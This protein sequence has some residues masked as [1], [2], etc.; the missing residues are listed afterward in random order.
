MPAGAA[1]LRLAHGFASNHFARVLCIKPF[2]DH[3]ERLSG[4]AVHLREFPASQLGKPRSMLDVVQSAL[5][6]IAFVGLTYAAWR[7]PL[8]TAV[9]LPGLFDD[10]IAAHAAFDVMSRAI[11]YREEYAPAGLVPLFVALMPQYQLLLRGRRSL[12]DIAELRGMKIRAPGD[13]G[14]RICRAL[15]ATGVP[16]DQADLYIALQRGTVDGALQ[17][18]ANSAAFNL[19]EVADA[20]TLNARLGSVACVHFINAGTWNALGADSRAV[21]REA[22]QRT[23]RDMVRQVAA[24]IA[25]DNR[26]L[27]ERGLT[28]LSLS[29]HVLAQFAARLSA[30]ET[31]WRARVGHRHPGA[32]AVLDEFKARVAARAAAR[33]YPRRCT[34]GSIAWS[35]C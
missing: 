8:S 19:H 16:I 4:G 25:R 17:T 9:E 29:G 24:L 7:M 2:L 30:V 13:T 31:R 23:S 27:A 32:G 21:L 18:S 3:V 6:D 26:R 28:L 35:A 34:P 14:L 12:E 11:L 5:A 1:R 20:L 10:V 22:G 15:G 33:A